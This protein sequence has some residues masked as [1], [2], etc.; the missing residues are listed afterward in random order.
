MV[1][2][3]EVWSVCESRMSIEVRAGT[4][5]SWTDVW[6]GSVELALRIGLA[7]GTRTNA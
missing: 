6:G 7:P 3:L 5:A 1:A 4:L 2:M